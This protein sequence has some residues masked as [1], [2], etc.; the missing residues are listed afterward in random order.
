MILTHLSLDKMATIFV[1][2]NFKCIFL[3]ANDRIPTRISVKFVPK[4]SIYNISTLVQIMAWC[5]IGDKP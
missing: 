3:N 1:D 2:N 4:G 5:Q